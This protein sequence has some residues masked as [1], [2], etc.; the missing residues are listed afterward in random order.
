MF[1]P[2]A[3]LHLLNI[4]LPAIW[5]TFY[6][7]IVAFNC[8]QLAA[9]IALLFR[10]ARRY[11]HIINS[12]IHLLGIGVIAFLLRAHDYVGQ[13]NFGG[14][15]MSPHTIATVNASIHRG[16]I[17]VLILAIGQWLWDTARWLRSKPANPVTNKVGA[18]S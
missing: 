12:V 18:A 15:P 4:N 9:K 5:H 10:P 8:V 17:L 3:V 13:A 14:S 1:G 16:L 2:N 7:I 6:W 11:Y